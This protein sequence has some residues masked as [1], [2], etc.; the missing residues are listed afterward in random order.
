MPFYFV[1]SV[2]LLIFLL[3]VLLLRPD[4]RRQA[5]VPASLFILY[6][7]ITEVL[8]FGDYWSVESAFPTV[9][10][11]GVV[12]LLE[13]LLFAFVAVGIMSTCYDFFLR[14]RP[15]QKVH[16]PRPFWAVILSV[17]QL[18]LFIVLSLSTE[19]LSVW[20]YAGLA[21]LFSLIILAIRSDLVLS[22]VGSG[23]ICGIGAFTFYFLILRIPGALDYL[24]E[25]WKLPPERFAVRIFQTPIPLTE[26]LWAFCAAV[27]FGI[28]YKFAAGSGY[29]SDRGA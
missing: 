12:F 9:H 23:L 14:R 11:L 6:G 19:I 29:Q 21:I 10:F 24:M 18:G 28:I 27:Y 7:P 16:R 22:A 3:I 4:L 1:G 5:L 13:D 25:A 20:V 17:A 15:V 26:V 8:Y 2:A